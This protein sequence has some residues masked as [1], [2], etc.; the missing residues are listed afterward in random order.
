[1]YRLQRF[2]LT[3]RTQTILSAFFCVSRNSLTRRLGHCLVAAF[4]I[5]ASANAR[6]VE[7]V[8]PAVSLKGVSVERI[9]LKK[10][11][12]ETSFL[13]QIDN[14]G[15]AFKLKDLSYRLTL[16]DKQAAEGKYSREIRVPGHSSATV[17]L[18]CTVDLSALPGI[19]WGI[20]WG[21][22]ELRYQFDTEF[23]VPLLPQISPRLKSTLAGDLSLV[24]TVNGWTARLKEHLSDK[25]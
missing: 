14:P 25:Q 12:A 20:V 18:P 23:T 1:M 15:P 5:T 7:D 19:A 11:A 10:A 9:D 16:N 22:F 17:E 24:R 3:N 8:K 6:P 4:L 2:K 13:I 21:G